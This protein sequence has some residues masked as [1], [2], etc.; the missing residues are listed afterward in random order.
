[1]IVQ[2]IAANTVVSRVILMSSP[3]QA[4]DREVLFFNNGGD[5]KHANPHSRDEN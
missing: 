1:M 5:G 2:M 4:W 3:Q